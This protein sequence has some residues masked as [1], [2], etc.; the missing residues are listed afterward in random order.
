MLNLASGGDIVSD[1]VGIFSGY[2][3]CYLSDKNYLNTRLFFKS[4]QPEKI[5]KEKKSKGYENT[6]NFGEMNLELNKSLKSRTD[7]IT[8]EIS[9]HEFKPPENVLKWE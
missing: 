4:Q 3:Y 5:L 9:E 2:I 1:I 6:S 8:K 7:S